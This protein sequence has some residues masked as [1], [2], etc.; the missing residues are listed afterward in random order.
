MANIIYVFIL[1][2]MSMPVIMG[3][4]KIQGVMLKEEC[5]A[6]RISDELEEIVGLY[7]KPTIPYIIKAKN[8]AGIDVSMRY[9]MCVNSS[10]LH[11]EEASTVVSDRGDT[12]SP[13]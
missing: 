7:K 3:I 11:E 10:T 1:K 5:N 8:I 4:I 2:A 12:L 9:L 6:G 13:K